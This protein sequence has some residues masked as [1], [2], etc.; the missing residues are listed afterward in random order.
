MKSKIKIILFVLMISFLF[1][2]SNNKK[3][4]P[5]RTIDPMDQQ[6]PSDNCPVV[7]PNMRLK[8]VTNDEYRDVLLECGDSVDVP[9]RVGYTFN[10][11]DDCKDGEGVVYID[12]KGQCI[13]EYHGTELLMLWPDYTPNEYRITICKEKEPLTEISDLI[14]S[15]NENFCDDLPWEKVLKRNRKTD[16]E[17]SFVIVGFS[18]EDFQLNYDDKN[19]EF[20]VHK[21]DKYVNHQE[22]TLCLNVITSD[23]TDIWQ[24]L[25]NRE[26]TNKGLLEQII[27]KDKESCDYF[28]IKKD[29][30]IESLQEL[31]YKEVKYKLTIA[32]TGGDGTPR[33]VITSKKIRKNKEFKEYTLIDTEKIEK[34]EFQNGEFVQKDTI[35]IE[36]LTGNFYV[37]YNSENLRKKTWDCGAITMELEF[38]K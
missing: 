17:E 29:I 19:K 36:D 33:I 27:G 30:D 14:C 22:K 9:N 20:T 37:Y 5:T 32:K 24:C 13:K 34:E 11:Y 35:P 2:C 26:I 28:S 15:Y 7:E 6:E 3:D 10:G 12:E 31:G 1:G 25:D 18:A 23:I 38:K 16:N 4:E 8:S 21:L